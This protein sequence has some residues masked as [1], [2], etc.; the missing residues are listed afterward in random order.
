MSQT[1]RVSLVVPVYN[2]ED[3]LYPLYEKI[4]QS[5]DPLELSWELVLV[6]DGSSDKSPHRMAELAAR[7]PR[8]V[9]VELRRNFGQTA[10][11]AAGFD[12]SSG[13][14]VVTLDAD[15]QNDPA[16]IPRLLALVA[17]GYD[18]VSGWRRNRQDEFFSRTLPSK[19]AN[20]LISLTTGVHLHDYGCTLKV[21]RRDV[22]QGL[23]LYGEMHRFLPALVAHQG[24]RITEVAVTHHPRLHGTSKYGI[25]RTFKVLL[26]LLTVKFL[27][28]YSTKPIYVFGGIG[29]ALLLGGFGTAASMVYMK[30]VKGI[31]MILT[32]L[33][34]LSALL[35]ILGMQ[36]LMLGLLAE[37]VVRTYFESQAKKIYVVRQVRRGADTA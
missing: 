1:P 10:A 24:A 17:E 31:S 7:D 13:E 30:L 37:L 25:M 21:Y 36:A 23:N 32:P 34:V 16:D 19:L 15:L 8:V 27:G 5:L 28:A 33:P 12:H 14:L 9:S 22:L 26:D 29:M 18:V 35:V 4:C 3:N 6:D 2:E 20:R 11:M